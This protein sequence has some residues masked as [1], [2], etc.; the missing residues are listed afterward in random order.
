MKKLRI[1]VNSKIYEVLVEVLQDDDEATAEAALPAPPRV[2]ATAPQP[3]VA[4][5]APTSPAGLPLVSDP[6]AILSPIAGT[7]QKVFVQAGS[8]ME[9]KSPVVLLDAMKMD[10]YIYAPRGGRVAEI[11]TGPGQSVQ[12]GQ[13]LIRYSATE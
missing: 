12:I 2:A 8:S 6:N 13:V 4:A 10:T 5:M 1:T 11:C 7:V 9:A 3:V